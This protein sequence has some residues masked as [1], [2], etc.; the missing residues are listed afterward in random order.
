MNDNLKVNSPKSY[1]SLINI[2]DLV[3]ILYK[4]IF[5][6]VMLVSVFSIS[7]VFFA[8]SLNNKY[9]SSAILELSNLGTSSDS[10]M[11]SSE[12]SSLAALGGISLSSGTNDRSD[13]VLKT[14]TS[15]EFLKHLISF[16]SV[17]ENLFASK[18]FDQS[19][20]EIIYDQEI[21]QDGKWVRKAKEN[22]SPE[23]SYHEVYKKIFLNNFS[24]KKDLDS[25]FIILSFEHISPIFAYDF[26]TLIIYELNSITRIKDLKETQKMNDYLEDQLPLTKEKN[27]KDT[28]YK[29]IAEELK[30]KMIANVNEDYILK[31][32]DPPFIPE[33]K[34]SPNRP[35]ICILGFLLGLLVGFL[36]CLIKF[37]N[38]NK[39]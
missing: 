25:G 30:S 37:Y 38:T 2:S 27:I 35:L 1:E 26:L 13:Y 10:S 39:N 21:F 34:S 8:L 14:L 7:S 12:Y 36:V 5:L 29:L 24:A 3:E 9:E 31:S 19:T 20:K 11:I 6:F 32:I 17:K 22:R 33:F 23:P 16:E 4:N 18:S 15:R 28:I